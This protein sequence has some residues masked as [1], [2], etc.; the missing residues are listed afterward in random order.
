MSSVQ[1]YP[2][3]PGDVESL[4]NIVMQTGVDCLFYGIQAALFIAACAM[5]ARQD[6][7][8][9]A[10]TVA[11]IGLFLSSL[12]GVVLNMVFYLVQV[13][14]FGWG[15]DS[16]WGFLERSNVAIAA[17][18]R[19]NYFVSDAIVVWRAW[20]L[21]PDSRIAKGLLTLCLGGSLVGVIVECVWSVQDLTVGEPAVRTLM[22]T[23]P[24]LA[25]NIVAT[26]L[27]GV[28][29]WIYRRDIKSSF[30][31]ATKTTRVE[32]VLV[33]LVE[34]GLVYCLIWAV[35]LVINITEGPDTLAV[36][37]VI[38]AAY[39]TIAGIYPTFIVLV[40]AMQ[41][42]AAESICGGTQLSHSVHFASTWKGKRPSTSGGATTSTMNDDL[43]GGVNTADPS[44]WS[45]RHE[46]LHNGRQEVYMMTTPIR[47]GRDP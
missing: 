22:M 43:N 17:T 8:S 2:L 20:V 6:N 15:L 1:Y 44:E 28:Q 38:S 11:I 14:T 36:Y 27:V 42:S 4:K 21:W 37:G 47:D 19:F 13:P 7:R 41:R 46:A 12:V 31:P 9:R 26:A 10:V 40:V 29:V 35:Y 5:L 45:Q 24:L 16:I 3:A 39:H 18:Y 30:G 34:S 32:R 33:L 23:V 25:T